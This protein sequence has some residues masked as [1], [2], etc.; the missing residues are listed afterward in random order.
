M[1]RPFGWAESVQIA[2]IAVADRS[3]ELADRLAAL[4]P[5][6]NVSLPADYRVPASG[7]AEPDIRRRD[8]I[9]R[10]RRARKQGPES[11]L[12]YEFDRL[13]LAQRGWLAA[14]VRAHRAVCDGADGIDAIV[15]IQ[16]GG[17]ASLELVGRIGEVLTAMPWVPSPPDARDTMPPS[18]DQ[19][20]LWSQGLR[21]ATRNLE[22]WAE[23]LGD[24]AG[25]AR[26]AAESE[27]LPQVRAGIAASAGLKEANPTV[28]GRAEEAIALAGAQESPSRMASPP[29]ETAG[30][31]RG[32]RGKP[33]AATHQ[34]SVDPMPPDP[35][36]EN[37]ISSSELK[38][39]TGITT[40]ALRNRVR[41]KEIQCEVV[42]GLRW[43][44]EREVRETWPEETT[45]TTFRRTTYDTLMK[46]SKA[47]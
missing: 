12:A 30:E 11:E 1:G 4:A 6:L 3:N 37:W 23:V 14:V 2:L 47:V 43:C 36:S 7:A 17:R 19:Q 29:F 26:P 21:E 18:E 32:D 13:H 35:S 20:S 16:G 5:H 40:E 15:E 24:R 28:T 39:Q 46:R 41:R 34:K 42:N 22:V 27:F 8:E 38:D 44:P 25:D 31:S 10:S 45:D 9:R 33:L